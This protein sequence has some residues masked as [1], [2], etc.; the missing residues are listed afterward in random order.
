MSIRKNKTS[1]AI[2]YDGNYLS[3]VS[4]YYGSNN[5]VKYKLNLSAL[6]QYIIDEAE[7]IANDVL[8]DIYVA[9]AHYYRNRHSAAEA[10][11]RKN[12]LYRDRITDDVLRSENIES[13]YAPYS[14][15]DASFVCSWL[16]LDLLDEHNVKNFDF[17]V[18]VVGDS[19]YISIIN[20]L[21][22][23]GVDTMVV[24]WDVVMFGDNAIDIKTDERLFSAATYTI[25]VNVALDQ[26]PDKLGGLLS[27]IAGRSQ[28][29][30]Y[31][32]PSVEIETDESEDTGEREISEVLTLKTN[33]G[34][35]SFPNNNLF[36]RAQDYI[37]DF[38]ELTVGDTVEFVVE[39]N[40]DGE[41]TAKKVQK[42]VSNLQQFS[43]DDFQIDDSF[44]DWEK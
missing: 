22:S 7:A 14:Q 29:I 41:S 38:A 35:I 34:F 20:K 6:H 23:K 4:K 19:S 21:K 27:P 10:I 30:K 28:E 3:R 33:Y 39:Q 40:E 43:D 36:F 1:V 44:I 18:L 8:S 24:G 37:G 2:F 32:T 16:S 31:G 26:T 12:Q 9:S 5:I 25:V 17:V 15:C 13:H 42:A 11:H